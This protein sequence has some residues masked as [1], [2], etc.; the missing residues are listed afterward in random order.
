[1]FIKAYSSIDLPGGKQ[2]NSKSHII[3]LRLNIIIH[4]YA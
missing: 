3:K 1:M 4:V 2:L